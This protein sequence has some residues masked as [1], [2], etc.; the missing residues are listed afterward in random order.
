MKDTTLPCPRC[1]AALPWQTLDLNPAVQCPACQ[2]ELEIFAFP[3]LLRS[4]TQGAAAALVVTEGESACFF[5]PQ[6]KAVVHCEECGR[7]LCALCDVDLNGKHF[8]PTCLASGQRKGRIQ[9]LERTRTRYDNIA[10]YT[11][12]LPLLLCFFSVVVTAPIALYVVIRYWKAPPSLVERSRV[13][14]IIAAV[15]AVIELP[16]GVAFWMTFNR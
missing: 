15:V 16:L 1:R 14:M 6:K 8:C 9:T 7:F 10:L 4:A 13:R 11:A 12:I 3:A 2:T 5:H